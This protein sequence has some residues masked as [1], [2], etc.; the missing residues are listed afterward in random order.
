MFSGLAMHINSAYHQ[1][2]LHVH[3]SI[4]H[5]LWDLFVE[6]GVNA[7]AIGLFSSSYSWLFCTIRFLPANLFLDAE[8]KFWTVTVAQLIVCIMFNCNSRCRLNSPIGV[9]SAD[10]LQLVSTFRVVD[11][12]GCLLSESSDDTQKSSSNDLLD[13]SECVDS[14]C[15][16]GA[17]C[18]SSNSISNG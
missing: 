6:R 14:I 10:R 4:I 15:S 2:L 12:R 9:E 13:S 16:S 3:R 5:L 8:Q 11:T 17:L 7:A 18:S 1:N